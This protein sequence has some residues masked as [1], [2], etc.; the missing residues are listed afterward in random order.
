MRREQMD[1]LKPVMLV[2]PAVILLV[3]ANRSNAT[4]IVTEV[5]HNHSAWRMLAITDVEL[6]RV[7][8]SL[9]D[10]SAAGHC[11]KA[12]VSHYLFLTNH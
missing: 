1:N 11:L 3:S 7:T 10:S 2:A 8:V 9:K 12:R 5:E 6:M 4:H